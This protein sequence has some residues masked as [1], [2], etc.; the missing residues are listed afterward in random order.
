VTSGAIQLPLQ[1]LLVRNKFLSQ[2]VRLT[3]E[4]GRLY[5]AV[6]SSSITARVVHKERWSVRVV[7]WTLVGLCVFCSSAYCSGGYCSINGVRVLDEF[8]LY[9]EGH[10]VP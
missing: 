7:N 8:P 2:D 5:L 6:E 1:A 10:C 3:F 4:S 9:T